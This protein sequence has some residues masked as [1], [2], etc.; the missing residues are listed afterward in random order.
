MRG[1]VVLAIVLAVALPAAAQSVPATASSHRTL[2]EVQRDLAL[3]Q[4]AF[5]R[6]DRL[7]SL[8]QPGARAKLDGLTRGLLA[9]LASGSENVDLFAVTQRDVRSKFG[10]ISSEQCDLLSFCVLA[11][12]ARIL[13]DPDK[14]KGTLNGLNEMSE[15]TS[16]R[17]Q[18][19]MDRRSKFLSTLSNI[20]KKIRTTQETLVQNMK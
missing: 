9:H 6:A 3:E 7:K 19:T 8:L 12:G 10:P 1:F 5:A 11:E 4:T 20:M 14:L 18:M 17:L 2:H 15:E 16:L 13:T